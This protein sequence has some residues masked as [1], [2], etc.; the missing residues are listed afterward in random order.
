MPTSDRRRQAEEPT[1][2]RSDGAHL[3]G[4][5]AELELIDSLLAGHG[6]AVRSDEEPAATIEP[7]I[8]AYGHPTSTAPMGGP[9]DECAVVDESG[10]VKV[11]P[12]AV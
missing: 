4:R 8:S 7:G 12:S 2:S 6:D 11:S 3:L 10:T 9:D 5:S 1:R